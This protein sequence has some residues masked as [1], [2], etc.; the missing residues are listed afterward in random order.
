MPRI[1]ATPV[2][3]AW[4]ARCALC[5]LCVLLGSCL[6]PGLE[7][8][9]S[10]SDNEAPRSPAGGHTDDAG[11]APGGGNFGNSG[12]SGSGGSSGDTTSD[13]DEPET[14]PDRGPTDMG[15]QPVGE[16]QDPD[17]DAG[18]DDPADSP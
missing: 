7:P 1:S 14:G 18:T 8:P 3:F 2:P 10:S 12:N 17:V 9:G 16:G 5:A 11:M 15:G 4:L 6:G 13:P